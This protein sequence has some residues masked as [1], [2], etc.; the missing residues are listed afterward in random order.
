[1]FAGLCVCMFTCVC[2][3]GGW[4]LITSTLLGHSPLGL[5]NSELANLA[6]L[7]SQPALGLSNAGQGHCG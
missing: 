5:L 2:A 6:S 3:R 7:A 1:M 4:G